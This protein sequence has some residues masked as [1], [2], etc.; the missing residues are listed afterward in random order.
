LDSAEKGEE[1]EEKT[2]I[3]PTAERQ[4]RSEK[5]AENKEKIKEKRC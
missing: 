1:A 3:K 5:G 4:K 2:A